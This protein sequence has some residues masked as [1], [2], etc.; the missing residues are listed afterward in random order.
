VRYERDDDRVLRVRFESLIRDYERMVSAILAF[1]GKSLEDHVRPR[2]HF[3]PVKSAAGVGA[4]RDIG[5]QSAISQ[6]QQQLSEFCI[7]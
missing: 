4:W 2:Q 1:I 5:D 7:D 3:D 6:I